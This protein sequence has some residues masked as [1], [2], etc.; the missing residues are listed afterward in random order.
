MN[1][2]L[3]IVAEYQSLNPCIQTEILSRLKVLTFSKNEYLLEKGQICKGIYII[4]KGC[5]RTYLVKGKKEITTSFRT[6]KSYICSPY[7][8]LTQTPSNEY[9][10]AI[11]DT[12]CYFMSHRSIYSLL[13]RFIEFNVFVRKIYEEL[14]IR[15]LNL[16]NSI[17]T[18][19]A[20]ERY[21]LFMKESPKVLQRV[22][23][24]QLASFLG[25]SQETLSRM[26]SKV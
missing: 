11:E 3:N 23:L 17:R 13:E 18:L 8:F 16:L 1:Y 26:R 12:T 4:E 6:E 22:P 24:G 9:I 5:C 21:D 20:L 14:F 25:M 15:E 7:S 2:L 19:S 10:Q